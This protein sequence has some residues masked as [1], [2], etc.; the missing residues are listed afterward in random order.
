MK[1]IEKRMVAAIMNEKSFRE[2]N[3]EV[4]PVLYGN[5]AHSAVLEV[6]VYLFGNCIARVDMSEKRIALYTCGWETVTTT[7]RM[8]AILG[9][10]TGGAFYVTCRTYNKAIGKECRLEQHDQSEWNVTLEH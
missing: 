6:R 5:R 10:L 9:G 7:S 4:R 2:S 3:T 8:S 1:K